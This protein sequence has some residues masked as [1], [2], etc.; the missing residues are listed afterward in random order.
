MNPTQLK[1]VQLLDRV[2]D[3]DLGELTLQEMQDWHQAIARLT[4]EQIRQ[5][6]RTVGFTSPNFYIELRD[7]YAA[8]LAYKILYSRS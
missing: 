1:P 8:A 6:C 7:I 2:N 3:A 4:N 5:D